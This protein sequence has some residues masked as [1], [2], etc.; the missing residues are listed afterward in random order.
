M[1]HQQ[2]ADHEVDLHARVFQ[3]QQSLYAIPRRQ[4][5]KSP[6]LQLSRDDV[7][8]IV[9]IVDHQHRELVDITGGSIPVEGLQ[10]LQHLVRLHCSR[11]TAKTVAP[12]RLSNRMV[13]FSKVRVLAQLL[14]PISVTI[15][16]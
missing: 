3:H 9:V 8:N 4:D 6:L 11:A 13:R 7:A 10:R 1:G 2:I 16:W 15:V 12:V 14:I 5:A